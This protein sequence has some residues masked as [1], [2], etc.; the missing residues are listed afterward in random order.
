MKW[1]RNSYEKRLFAMCV[2][3]YTYI[4]K[5]HFVDRSITP[6]SAPPAS[7]PPAA[8]K[9]SARARKPSR[10]VVF[11]R[12]RHAGRR[13]ATVEYNPEQTP[14][15]PRR[16][17]RSRAAR[18]PHQLASLGTGARHC[19]VACAPCRRVS[20]AEATSGGAGRPR[21]LPAGDGEGWLVLHC[22]VACGHRRRARECGRQYREA[23]AGLHV[24]LH[25]LPGA[26]FVHDHK[27]TKASIRPGSISVRG[28]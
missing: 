15:Y 21:L 19:A 11:S 24:D 26:M 2:F 20:R 8:V 9:T 17:A 18:T 10:N 5:S 7:P 1:E 25:P 28:L 6:G 23:A 3:V 22:C 16:A 4:R 27:S 12:R 14:A 13:A